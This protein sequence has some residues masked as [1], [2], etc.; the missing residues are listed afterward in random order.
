MV[1]HNSGDFSKFK[2][3]VYFPVVNFTRS[4]D[5]LVAICS[6]ACIHYNGFH[7]AKLLSFVISHYNEENVSHYNGSQQQRQVMA[8]MS[9]GYLEAA[10]ANCNE[11]WPW[12]CC[13]LLDG[14]YFQCQTNIYI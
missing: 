3:V 6:A 1:L 8:E 12:C 2:P 9:L 14:H 4:T 7:I 13:C 11:I 10:V 5:C